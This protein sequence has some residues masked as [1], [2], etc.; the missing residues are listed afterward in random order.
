[1]GSRADG[2]GEK[3]RGEGRKRPVLRGRS[4]PELCRKAEGRQREELGRGFAAELREDKPGGG[5]CP[6]TAQFCLKKGLGGG[7]EGVA[8]GQKVR[9]GFLPASQSTRF[10]QGRPRPAWVR[11][12]SRKAFGISI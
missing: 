9:G 6:K 4:D 8:Q 1:M 3:Q 12:S 10:T 2:A 7:G 5:R 11:A